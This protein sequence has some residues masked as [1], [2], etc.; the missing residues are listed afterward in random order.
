[1]KKTIVI[2]FC[3]QWAT[4]TQEAINEALKLHRE[5]NNVEL[6]PDTNLFHAECVG[7]LT[8]FKFYYSFSR[9]I[10]YLKK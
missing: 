10:F 9:N 1:M 8:T 3:P 7:L 4:E 6:R 5:G 2:E